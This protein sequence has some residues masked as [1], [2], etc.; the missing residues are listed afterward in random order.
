MW[1]KLNDNFEQLLAGVSIVVIGLAL[2]VDR[3]YFF[4]PP[5]WASAMNDQRLDLGVIFLGL[6]IVIN[7]V[8]NTKKRG[9]RLTLLLLGTWLMW[10]LA[11]IQLGHA[12]YAGEFRMAHT[13]IGDVVVSLI[14]LHCLYES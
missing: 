10:I 5:A 14:C 7:A 12:F 4:W 6:L 3:N 1:R 8:K 9:W 13:I 11:L 2:L